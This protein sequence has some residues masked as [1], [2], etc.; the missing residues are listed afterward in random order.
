MTD[1]WRLTHL[2]VSLCKE[3]NSSSDLVYTSK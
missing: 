2:E 1:D 3:E